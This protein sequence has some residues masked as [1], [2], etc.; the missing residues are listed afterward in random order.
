MKTFRVFTEQLKEGKMVK[1]GGMYMTP[2]FAKK[3]GAKADDGSKVK[4]VDLSKIKKNL[5]KKRLN[6]PLR[7]ILER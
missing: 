5:L 3:I 1:S 7:Y 2:D 6:L 4:P